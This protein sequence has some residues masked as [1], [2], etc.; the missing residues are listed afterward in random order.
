MRMWSGIRGHTRLNKIRNE[1]IRMKSWGSTY[2]GKKYQNL[3]L[4]GLIM[5]G[6]DSL[7]GLVRIIDQMEG[8]PIARDRGRLRNTMEKTIK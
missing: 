5:Y 3:A 4:G 2:C 8:S 7:E 1:Y 6:E